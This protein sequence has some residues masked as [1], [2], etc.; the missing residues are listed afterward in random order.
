MHSL[1]LSGQYDFSDLPFTLPFYPAFFF[2]IAVISKPLIFKEEWSSG[3]K[4][5][6]SKE[7]I[8]L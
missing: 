3:P 4:C 5:C 7:L 6:Y 1:V 2:F 8:S